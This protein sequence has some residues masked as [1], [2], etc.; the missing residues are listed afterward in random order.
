M[1]RK[2]TMFGVVVLL[3][4]ASALVY[5][6]WTIWT[7]SSSQVCRVCNR[8]IH[9]MTRTVG[10]MDGKR[11]VFCCPTCALTEHHQSGEKVKLVEV[12]D[13]NTRSPLAPSNATF[14]AGSDLNCCVEDHVLLG[15]HEQVSPMEFDRCSPSIFAFAQRK[16][17]E[18]FQ[19][20][21]GGTILSF[22][23]LVATYQQ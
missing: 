13:F 16:E 6:G 20:Q 18:T 19:K 23:D 12:S 1:T 5:A 11:E 10:L 17:A 22:E 3:A 21:H 4:I 8:P 14:V 9:D 15:Q 7:S 2:G